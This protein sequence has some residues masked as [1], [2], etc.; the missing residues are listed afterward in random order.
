M[1]EQVKLSKLQINK[2]QIEGLPKNPRFI[3]DE[4]FEKLCANLKKY[5]KFL[6]QRPIVIKSWD[7]P[8]IL[9]GNMRFQGLKRL[10][11]KEVPQSWIKTADE[12][13][14]EELKA[15]VIIDNVPFGENDWDLLANEWEV[16]ELTDWGL[17][18]PNFETVAET[19][20]EDESQVAETISKAKEL[21][22]KWQ[23]ESGQ[24][25]KLGEHRLLCGDSTKTE[26]V[27]RALDG[28]KPNLMVTDPPYGVEYDASWRDD[29]AAKGLIGYAAS[30]VAPV[31]ND[32]RIDWSAAYQLFEG[33][34]FYC[35][36][37]GRHA[38][39]VQASI[40]IAGFEIRS[41]IIWAKPNF[42]ISRG[43]YNW[44]HEPCWYA[45]RKGEQ[46]SWIGDHSQTTLWEINRE[47]AAEGGHST[48]KPTECMARAIRNHEG[49]VYEP[50][51]G[52]GTTLIACEQLNRKCR[53]I[54]IAPEYVA[55]TLERWSNLTG[56]TP[57]L[58]DE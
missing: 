1:S 2:G 36:H 4:R 43:H 32:D 10:G 21:Q 58:I 28:L 24:L 30:S 41:Q 33:N 19:L 12:F 40:E 56:K 45:V 31:L 34:V 54:E 25:W 11:Y 23:T 9:G 26:D 27:E 57:E 35:W 52:S 48:Q 38:S 6:E 7:E 51:C 46:A 47:S 13:T 15:F 37:A 55:V 44:Q 39:E 16:D 29:A 14:E 42:A 49:D 53:A 20:E 18:I 5:P 17:D 3:K 8:I 22:E 50:F